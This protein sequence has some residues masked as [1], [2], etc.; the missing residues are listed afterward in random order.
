M[1]VE[2]DLYV[3]CGPKF[4]PTQ[5]QFRAL[6]ADFL[7]GRWTIPPFQ[8]LEGTT[9]FDWSASGISNTPDSAPK[10]MRVFY[11]GDDPA[12]LLEAWDRSP[13]G[14]KNLFVA[15]SAFRPDHPEIRSFLERHAFSNGEVILGALAKRTE[16]DLFDE[17]EEEFATVALQHYMSVSGKSGPSTL[18]GSALAR[19]LEKHFGGKLVE[20]CEHS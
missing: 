7:E 1:G 12:Q 10:K 19:I 4:V 14:K 9:D 17:E 15:F 8:L 2:V 18:R 3:A 5:A 20:A 13:Y 6:L 16:I 11:R